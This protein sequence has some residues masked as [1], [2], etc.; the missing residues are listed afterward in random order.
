MIKK[1]LNKSQ[2]TIEGKVFPVPFALGKIK[3]GIEITTA[4][5]LSKDQKVNQALKIHSQGKIKEAAKNYKQLISEGLSD[6]RVLSN[7]GIILKSEGNLKFIPKRGLGFAVLIIS[8]SS[9][10]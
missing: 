2:E 4:S 7:Y 6:Y 1:I 5:K 3:E 10:T 8:A 9:T